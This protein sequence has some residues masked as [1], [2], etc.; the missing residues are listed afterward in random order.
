MIPFGDRGTGDG[1]ALEHQ[2]RESSFTQLRG[3]GEADRSG[4]DH[5]NG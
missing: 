5:D 1:A 2:R 4:S 3:G